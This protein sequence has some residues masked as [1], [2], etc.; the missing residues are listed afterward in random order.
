MIWII[1]LFPV[2]TFSQV[3]IF[4]Y[5]ESEYDYLKLQEENYN[6]GYNKLRL[7]LE[8]QASD[9]VMI[10][11][12]IN[13]QLYHGKTDWDIID[14]IPNSISTD[15]GSLIFSL[16]DTLFLEN[17]YL[18]TS[19]SKF[20]LTF[21]RQPLSLGTGYAWN[22]LDIFNRKELMDPTYEQ[23]GINA[24]RMGIPLADRTHI[25]AIITPD[26]TWGMSTKMIQ[27][28]TGLSRFDMSFNGAYQYHLIPEKEIGYIYDEVY[29]VGTS[30]V[31]ELWEFGLWGETLWSLNIDDNFGEIL[32]GTDYTLDYG[33][34]LMCEYFHNS[35]GVEKDNLLF[36][37]YL[38]NY[39][40]EIHSLMQNYIFAMG[41]YNL[42]DFIASSMVVVGNLDDNSFILV[43]Q[44]DFDIF[45]DVSMGVL[46]SQSIGEEDTEFGIQNRAVRFRIRAYF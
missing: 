29:F 24:L 37:H 9:N 34:Y 4:G 13:F 5:Y 27:F 35:L 18:R 30:F 3:D 6:F 36:D 11:G 21:G 7:D 8:S 31:G 12:N 42:T 14:F 20:D 39:S 41:M 1:F 10:F 16:K 38:Y 32:F 43:P 33:L 22:P 26:S 2:L 45:E 25:D 17:I 28:K 23:P 40:G 44:I 46:L 15:I 19:F